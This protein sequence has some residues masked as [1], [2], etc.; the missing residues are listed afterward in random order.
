MMG[1]NAKYHCLC[2]SG[3]WPPQSEMEPRPPGR[4]LRPP[5]YTLR[6][7]SDTHTHHS[8]QQQRP[9]KSCNNWLQ[10]T[11]CLIL[12]LLG[13]SLSFFSILESIQQHVSQENHLF[14]PHFQ[15]YFHR[16]LLTTN[17]F[18]SVIFQF[19]LYFLHLSLSYIG[20][21]YVYV[22]FKSLFP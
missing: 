4:T 2:L 15:I 22:F 1:P 21:I 13:T 18:P 3:V 6:D 12:S 19:C 8:E 20:R 10:V 5:P 11:T 17:Y 14:D 16:V 9:R 7:P